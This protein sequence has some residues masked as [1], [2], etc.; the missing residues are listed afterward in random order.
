MVCPPGIRE[1]WALLEQV[2]HLSLPISTDVVDSVKIRC[3]SELDL[4]FPSASLIAI[5]LDNHLTS[6]LLDCMG[7]NEIMHV[8]SM[9]PWLVH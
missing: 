9:V 2:I 3:L 6:S 5:I 8:S 4:S 7:L 1:A